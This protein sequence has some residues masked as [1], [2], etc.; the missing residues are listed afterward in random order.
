MSTTDTI[1]KLNTKKKGSV[2]FPTDPEQESEHNVS[3]TQINQLN[4]MQ[5]ETG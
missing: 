1:N 2:C 4:K 3:P 5:S